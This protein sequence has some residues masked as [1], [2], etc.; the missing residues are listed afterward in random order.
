AVSTPQYLG[1]PIAGLQLPPNLL[2]A[3]LTTAVR[4]VAT[5]TDLFT[6]V[7]CPASTLNTETHNRP[8]DRSALNA[9]PRLI[10]PLAAS[11]LGGRDGL[12]ALDLLSRSPRIH[13]ESG[14]GW[15]QITERA[16]ALG[17]VGVLEWW[18]QRHRRVLSTCAFPPYNGQVLVEASR[19]GHVDVLEWWR[20]SGLPLPPFN[21]DVLVAASAAGHVVVLEWWRTGGLAFQPYNNKP[22][23]SA[24]AN[25]QVAALDWWYER[26]RKGQD[27]HRVQFK[28]STKAID[29]ACAQGHTAVLQWWWN[30]ATSGPENQRVK[31]KYTERPRWWAEQ[32]WPRRSYLWW[33]ASERAQWRGK[34]WLEPRLE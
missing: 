31:P 18:L 1:N 34:R 21:E 17:H 22:I 25:G 4:H 15:P 32:H 23:D 8:L 24:S 2:T 30:R 7:D 9:I 3:I 20:K 14:P 26:S 11:E 16:S 5:L 6:I 33:S 19:A 12:R 27:Q 29:V 28:V 13:V 10:T